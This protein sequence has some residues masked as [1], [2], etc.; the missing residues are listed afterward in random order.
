MFVPDDIALLYDDASGLPISYDIMGALKGTNNGQHMT[1]PVAAVGRDLLLRLFPAFTSADKLVLV[2]DADAYAIAR[3]HNM[4]ASMNFASVSFDKS[5]KM[6]LT[7]TPA[8]LP[9]APLPPPPAEQSESDVVIESI[10]PGSGSMVNVK[11]EPGVSI[12]KPVKLPES[13]VVIESTKPGSGS[14]VKVEPD[15]AIDTPVKPPSRKRRDRAA[16]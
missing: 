5:T 16:K 13:D 6:I 9:A 15:M 2:P 3:S 11:Q 7:G 8:N 1:L 14:M 10:K 12:D 4:F